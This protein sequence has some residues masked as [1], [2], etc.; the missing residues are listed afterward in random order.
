MAKGDVLSS[1][2]SADVALQVKQAAANKAPAQIAYN[3]AMANYERLQALYDA[4]AITKVECDNAKAK[5]KRPSLKCKA[6]R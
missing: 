4:G 1:L 5:T 3:E 2:D 6:P